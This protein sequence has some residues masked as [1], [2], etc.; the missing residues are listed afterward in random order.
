MGT[1][2]TPPPTPP[3]TATMPRRNV[4]T[5]NTSGQTHQ[6]IAESGEL[7]IGGGSVDAHTEA[8]NKWRM[9]NAA[10]PMRYAVVFALGRVIF[11]SLD[12]ISMVLPP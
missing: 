4:T 3:K 2:R 12:T 6:G 7:G 5:N 10:T 1:K 8:A 11:N 9:H